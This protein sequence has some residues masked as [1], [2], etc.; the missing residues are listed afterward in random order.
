[1]LQE[2]EENEYIQ[3]DNCCL[4]NFR[5]KISIFKDVYS[6][7]LNMLCCNKKGLWFCKQEVG[8]LFYIDGTLSEG[9][10]N[11]NN[12][13]FGPV[14]LTCKDNFLIKDLEIIVFVENNI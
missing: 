6:K 1:M 10:T 14:I 3:M 13:Y 5:P 11:K 2:T 8:D 12:T 7:G 9:R 4:V